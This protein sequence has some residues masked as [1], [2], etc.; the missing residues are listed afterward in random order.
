[1][2]EWYEKCLKNSSPVK[3]ILVLAAVAAMIGCADS[4]PNGPSRPTASKACA[5]GGGANVG[6]VAGPGEYWCRDE[7]GSVSL[8]TGVGK[9][10][11]IPGRYETVMQG[12]QKCGE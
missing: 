6:A 1:M 2:T 3:K 11:D 5:V 8:F 7:I 4:S 12:D 10:E 9:C